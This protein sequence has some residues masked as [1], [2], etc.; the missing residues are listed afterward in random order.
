MERI[1]LASSAVRSAGYDEASRTLE[2]EFTSGRVYQF[3]DVPESVYA[4]LLRTP[5]KGS[6]VT[7]MI[8]PKFSYRDVTS[9]EP[10]TRTADP[11]EDLLQRL[12]D[13]VRWLDPK[14]R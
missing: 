3:D 1:P 4:W 11:D 7:R 6:Y 10:R 5:S 8:N 13:S 14:P 12:Q 9:P 2:I